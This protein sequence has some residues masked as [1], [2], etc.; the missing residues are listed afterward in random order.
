MSEHTV[1]VDELRAKGVCA[2]VTELP[3]PAAAVVV[4]SHVA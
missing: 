1:A 4:V 2:S 3:K